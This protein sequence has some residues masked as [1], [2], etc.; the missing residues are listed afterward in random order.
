[1]QIRIVNSQEPGLTSKLLQMAFISQNS[2][3]IRLCFFI[4]LDLV[5]I[6]LHA[7]P[8][9]LKSPEVDVISKNWL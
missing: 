7:S 6:D 1:M 5:K 8:K 9:A 2:L 4:L 3:K